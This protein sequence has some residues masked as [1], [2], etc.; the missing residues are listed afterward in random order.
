MARFAIVGSGAWGTALAAHVA[1]LEHEVV[2]WAF[3]RDVADEITRNHTNTPFLPGVTLPDTIRASYDAVA[4]VEGAEVVILVPPSIHLRAVS[5]AIAAAIPRDAVVV[6]A[7]KGIEE[8][9]LQLMSQVL[10]ETVPRLEPERLAFLSGPTFAREVARG[11]PTDVV[12]ASSG[13]VAARKIQQ[14]VHSV[15]MRVYSSADPIGVQVGGAI[16]NVLAIAT[17]ACDGLA[18]GTN[19][20]AALITRGL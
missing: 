14:L 11:L 4:V 15:S 5:T 2:M 6:V 12:V 16:K 10:A 1:R 20:R 18:F 7:T 9:S 3:E 17:G 8:G 19:A 13:M